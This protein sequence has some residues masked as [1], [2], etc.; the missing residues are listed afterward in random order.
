MRRTNY[1]NSLK[2]GGGTTRENRR[3]NLTLP[4]LAGLALGPAALI[5]LL[6]FP[7]PLTWE[8]QCLL[9]VIMMTVIYWILQPIP[10]PVTSILALTL[11]KLLDNSSYT[12]V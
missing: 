2:V 9:A 5:T 7:L 10:I 4:K 3:Q 1:Q 6:L 8:Q 12:T 11:A